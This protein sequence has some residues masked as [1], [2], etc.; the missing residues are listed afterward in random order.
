MTP[1]AGARPRRVPALHVDSDDVPRFGIGHWYGLGVIVVA[2]ALIG[3]GI[4]IG[5]A[6]HGSSQAR[7]TL[8]R[9][10]DPAV[11][12]SGRLSTA[13]SSEVGAVRAY[14]LSHAGAAPADYRRAVAD[15]TRL[16]RGVPDAGPARAALARFSAVAGT[17]RRE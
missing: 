9:R 17:W 6:V 2:L 13:V 3:A 7:V 16:L 4:A 15:M 10:V 8:L 14:A 11:P 1:P 12:A 5:M